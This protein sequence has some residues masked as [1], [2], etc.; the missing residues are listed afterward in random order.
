MENELKQKKVKELIRKIANIFIVLIVGVLITFIGFSTYLANPD[1]FKSKKVSDAD[2]QP[3]DVEKEMASGFLPQNV[4]YG[5]K[6]LSETQKYLGP[7]AEDPAMRHAGNNLSCT[8]CHL[9]N[10]NHPG[11]ASWAGVV[12]RF[13]SFGGRSNSIGTIEDRING[14]F[15][16]SMNGKKVGVDTREMKAM[17]SYMEWLAEDMP[18]E[19]KEYYAGFTDIEI[20]DV[21]V[22]LEFGKR[23]YDK[24]C[25]VCHQ[26]DGQGMRSA[27]FSEG[28]QFPPLW[29]KD[30]Y[31]EGAGMHRVIT[32][33]LFIKANM[34]SGVATKENPVLT[35]EEA[36]HVAGYINSF[37]RPT[38]SNKE[39]DFPDKKLK[40][41]S[42]PYGPWEDDF[43]AEQHKYGPYQPIIEYY[44]ETYN[45]SK[46][47]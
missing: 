31:N 9:E 33:A 23:V 35:D 43:S 16:R 5:Y 4:L 36:Y 46:N 19:Q 12:E 45:I 37:D 29:G 18:K 24:D 7:Q 2:W 26:D 28:Y 40:P 10:G 14:C 38:K 11:G 34:P 22:D 21:A 32:S 15:E 39:A 13:P 27:D 47:K 17:V 8:S 42:T 25:A 6:L 20:P 1:L 3:K 44:K 30:T 41:V